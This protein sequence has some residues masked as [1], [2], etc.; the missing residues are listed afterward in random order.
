MVYSYIDYTL[1]S[2]TANNAVPIHFTPMPTEENGLLKMKDRRYDDP[3]D[4]RMRL[5]D[6]IVR[7][8]SE[9]VYVEASG[10][11]LKVQCHYL[12]NDKKSEI[13][14]SS[15]P[16]LDITSP[17]LGYCNVDKNM[18]FLYRMPLRNQK[19]GLSRENCQTIYETD[20]GLMRCT[21]LPK[22]RISIGKTILNQ[23]DDFDVCLDK[24]LKNSRS[25]AFNR[26]FGFRSSNS[27]DILILKYKTDTAGI[28]IIPDRLGLLTPSFYN[29]HYLTELSPYMEV[30]KCS[31]S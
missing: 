11:S 5:H 25:I 22:E 4:V 2:V 19:Q 18:A 15:H 27:K 10:E 8:R 24:I 14:D 21:G 20:K 6:T 9:P 12:L 23:F 17:P 16:D 30:E 13:V 1:S 29:N 28:Y 26:S 31:N 7:L 3:A